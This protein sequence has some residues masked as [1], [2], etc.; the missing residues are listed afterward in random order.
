MRVLR[1][2]RRIEKSRMHCRCGSQASPISGGSSF[3]SYPSKQK[4]VMAAE[5]APVR[6]KDP[7]DCLF[8]AVSG[9]YAPKIDGSAMW[10]AGG[11]HTLQ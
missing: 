3:G 10:T 8:H 7:A 5:T 6:Q 1:E 11:E 9:V 2:A 4:E